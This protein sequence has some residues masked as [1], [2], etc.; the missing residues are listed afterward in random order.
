MCFWLINQQMK[1][2]M[3]IMLFFLNKHLKEKIR[4]NILTISD[5]TIFP[6]ELQ[7]IMVEKCFQIISELLHF[8]T[9]KPYQE[10]G[11]SMKMAQEICD[12]LKATYDK[13]GNGNPIS[14][15]IAITAR[16]IKKVCVSYHK[17]LTTVPFKK[18][19]T[20]TIFYELPL[21]RLEIA[22]LLHQK[23]VDFPM[24]D[25]L[26]E[27]KFRSLIERY[28]HETFMVYGMQNKQN[29]EIFI[30]TLISGIFEKMML[31]GN[32]YY[33]VAL[34]SENSIPSLVLRNALIASH[35]SNTGILPDGKNY[36]HHT[37][38]N[39]NYCI[40][41]KLNEQSSQLALREP[42]C[43][44][45]T[46]SNIPNYLPEH[47]TQNMILLTEVQKILDGNTLEHLVKSYPTYHSGYEKTMII[48][49]NDS[50]LLSLLG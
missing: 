38:E 7:E 33:Y 15:R 9:L 10:I 37:L 45:I 42:F 39:I 26:A 2:R 11:L 28:I 21:T 50:H 18:L 23:M 1:E 49:Q 25:S 48:Q 31:R 22:A 6:K 8:V 17:E 44:Y 29:W 47:L 46:T 3:E 19:K 34:G 35:F 24:R 5:I 32:G 41:I 14:F 20:Y 16:H 40:G 27:P 13:K 43:Q 30:D 36:R 4:H 12:L